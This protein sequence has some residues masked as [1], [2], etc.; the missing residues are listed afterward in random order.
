MVFRCHYLGWQ[1]PFPLLVAQW[2]IANCGRNGERCPDFSDCLV[3]VPTA[4]SGKMLIE[5]LKISLKRGF[6][7]PLTITPMALFEVHPDSWLDF[8]KVPTRLE[9]KLLWVNVLHRAF[10]NR[11]L[12]PWALEGED[13]E[14]LLSLAGGV[15]RAQ[16]ELAE[17]EMTLKDLA[18]IHEE[19]LFKN[20]QLLESIY[21]ETLEKWGFLDPLSHLRS[22]LQEPKLP[23]GIKR[24]IVAGC[25]DPHPLAV[26]FLEG[27]KELPAIEVLLPGEKSWATLFDAQGLPVEERC[28]ELEIPIDEEFIHL[29]GDELS[30]AEGIVKLISGENYG[31]ATTIGL[32]RSKVVSLLACKLRS[33]GIDFLNY[34]G[35]SYKETP[36]YDFFL[37]LRELL[38]DPS[39][40]QFSSWA[41]SPLSYEWIG[42]KQKG[43]S[44]EFLAFLDRMATRSIAPSLSDFFASSHQSSFEVLGL[45]RSFIEDLRTPQWPKR[46]LNFLAVVLE[47]SSSFSGEMVEQWADFIG[48]RIYRFCSLA[49]V[50]AFH[51]CSPFLSLMLDEMNEE[52]FFFETEGDP[53]LELK[54]WLE[55]LWDDSMHLVLA[56]FQERDVPKAIEPDF[57]LTDEIRKKVGLKRAERRMARDS[58]LLAFLVNRL[59]KGARLDVFLS[60][61]DQQGELLLPSRLL[62][63]QKAERLARRVDFLFR[64]L[65]SKTIPKPKTSP[66]KLK[67]PSVGWK[68]EESLSVSALNDYLSCPFYFYLKHRLGWQPVVLPQGELLEADFGKVLHEV[69]AVFGENF[70]GVE[71]EDPSLI[72]SFLE[73]QLEKVLTKS[74]GKDRT[75]GLQFQQKAMWARLKSFASFQAQ[76]SREGW[77]IWAVE[78]KFELEIENVKVRGR[79]DRIDKKD[80]QFLIIDYKTTEP[81]EPFGSHL[82]I[83]RSTEQWPPAEAYFSFQGKK[84]RW[85]DFQLP[86]YYHGL[87]SMGLAKNPQI[88]FCF[89]S[90]KEK[91]ELL[92]CWPAESSSFLEESLPAIARVIR[93]IKENKFWPPNPKAESWRYSPWDFWFDRNPAEIFDPPFELFLNEK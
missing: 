29:H 13:F 8:R 32:C 54:G 71:L 30:M 45:I 67:L 73:D 81:R 34:S 37:Q 48:K 21:F 16:D 18:S 82:G 27:L 75:L 47:E 9:R 61:F 20:L 83:P 74:Y 15:V 53:K 31:E 19:E 43:K 92:K 91:G 46:L 41:R 12:G 14:N 79:I 60:K 22:L 77:R 7:P 50:N 17:K 86:L 4:L 42:K 65:P 28:K 35:I 58:L 59:S 24:L 84:W 88:G 51:G 6:V 10:Q 40:T 2:L 72:F 52:S 23:P 63:R 70:K 57:I 93:A 5:A 66:F 89:L 25:L 33:S 26:K 78:K 55:L 44:E 68:S 80:E 85:L 69:L 64:F 49:S 38:K 36:F 1:D 11:L 87:K 76:W 56:G 62:F 3:L 90:Q 39:W